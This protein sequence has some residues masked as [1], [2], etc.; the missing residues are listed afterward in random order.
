MNKSKGFTIIEL[1]VVIAIIAVLAAIVLVNV[2]G[3]INKGKDAAAEGNLAGML[4]QGAYWYDANNDTFT[5]FL[6]ASSGGANFTDAIANEGYSAPNCNYASGDTG[7][8]CDVI[9]KV[10]N[11]HYCVDSTGVKKTPSTCTAG[12]C[13]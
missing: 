1:I 5:G 3:Y 7:W 12:L 11:T 9:L 13:S 2:T 10:T 8:C 4:T 6:T